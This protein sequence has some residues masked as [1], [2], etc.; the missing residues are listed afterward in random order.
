MSKCEQVCKC[1]TTSLTKTVN[2]SQATRV[3][4]C[5]EALW[6]CGSMQV[7]LCRCACIGVVRVHR[8]QAMRGSAWRSGCM[9]AAKLHLRRLPSLTNAVAVSACSSNHSTLSPRTSL[10]AT[11][12]V[13][14]ASV[15]SVGDV[16][17]LPQHVVAAHIF[18]R[19]LAGVG[20][21]GLWELWS[22]GAAA[23][24]CPTSRPLCCVF[25]PVH[26]FRGVACRSGSLGHKLSPQVLQMSETHCMYPFPCSCPHRH[27]HTD[28]PTQTRPHRHAH[29]D[30]PCTRAQIHHLNPKGLLKVVPASRARQRSTSMDLQQT[31]PPAL[32]QAGRCP[33]PIRH[34]PAYGLGLAD[35]CLPVWVR[36]THVLSCPHGQLTLKTC[37]AG[38]F[39]TYRPATTCPPG[40]L[41]P[42]TSPS[43][44]PTLK[45]GPPGHPTR[46]TCPPV[47][48]PYLCHISPT[49]RPKPHPAD[50]SPHN[51]RFHTC[52]PASALLPTHICP[53]V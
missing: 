21:T 50:P 9:R 32:T 1:G 10:T 5:R 31:R 4:D 52:A 6:R 12:R 53:G 34:R 30:T 47:V 2:L 40:Q 45:T 37:V 38:L 19:G 33:A 7:W 28:T 27:A 49:P 46:K 26:L 24:A 39:T 25:R 14:E 8:K 20:G 15:G 3:L 17:R 41:N 23:M 13:C 22:S 11:W 42:N 43:G 36:P 16:E 18:D 48:H 35:V 51:T 44:Y 29:T